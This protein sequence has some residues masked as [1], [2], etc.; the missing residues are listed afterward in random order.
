MSRLI[1][2]FAVPDGSGSGGAIEDKSLGVEDIV[3]MLEDDTEK[4]EVLDLE[5][6]KSS[7]NDKTDKG[8]STPK[9]E[10]KDDD[11][12][13]DDDEDK[14]DEDLDDLEE[15]LKEPDEA[16]LEAVVVPARRKD[17]LSKY[18]KLFEDFPELEKSYYRERK[19]TEILPTIEDA[20]EAVEAKQNLDI[21]EAGLAKG[22]I[23]SILKA[24]KDTDEGMFHGLVDNL[25]EHLRTTDKS[26]HLHVVGNVFK[27][28]LAAAYTEGKESG[29][30][31]LKA[32][33]HVIYKYLFGTGNYEPPT[34]LSK[35]VPKNEEAERVAQEREQLTRERFETARN[36]L[37]LRLDNTL[38]ATIAHNIDPKGLMTDFV[39]QNAIKIA[40]EKV[41]DLI[42]NDARFK[43]ILNQYWR[44]AGQQNFSKTSIEAIRAAYLSRA[45]SLLPTVLKTVKNEALKGV[46]RKAKDGEDVESPRKKLLTPGR[47]ASPSSSSGKSPSERAKGIPQGM[48][49]ADYLLS[50][51]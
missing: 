21:F 43:Q 37:A 49:T 3:T 40:G 18:P 48:S 1:E 31:S 24:V 45:K 28:G 26:A 7:K 17:I 35:A 13:V 39:K 30:D 20:R 15:D 51:D 36:D 50:D 25:M 41:Q 42:R 32:A 8:K 33:A 5:K 38:K 14:D 23:G 29:D 10:D 22:D 34:T 46:S 11:A 27:E 6:P 4:D 9:D 2:F 16:E 19:Y 47:S 44:R 12:E